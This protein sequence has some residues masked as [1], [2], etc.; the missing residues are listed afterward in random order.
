MSVAPVPHVARPRAAS[1][2][3]VAALLFYLLWNSLY[4]APYVVD[5]AFISFRYARMLL[6]GE[7]LVFNVGERVEGFS[8]FLWVMI[9]AA[10]LALGLP[11]VTATKAV[12]TASGLATGAMTFLL[13][14][15]VLRSRA[16][17]GTPPLDPAPWALLACAGVCVNTSLAVWMQSGLETAFFGL[18]VLASCLR[19]EVERDG[20]RRLP[21]SALLFAAMWMT[22]PEAPAYALY[23]LVRRL[24]SRR[25]EPLGGRDLAWVATVLALVVPYEVW[26]VVYYGHLL[27]NTHV[28][29]VESGDASFF[30]RLLGEPETSQLY[31]FVVDQGPALPALLAL[32]VVGCVRGL[33]KLPVA[34]W[35]PLASGA[36]FLLYAWSDWMPRY[37]FCVPILPFVFLT[38]AFGLR[39][40]DDLV[41]G[42]RVVRGAWLA[43]VA[44]LFTGYAHEQA[45]GSY[46][47]I[48]DR[49]NYKL[50]T[51]AR[52]FWFFDVPAQVASNRLFPLEDV[53]WRILTELRA[54]ETAAIRDIGV[55]GYLTMNPIWDVRG[56]VTPSMARARNGDPD[57]L[58]LVVDE[59]LDVRPTFILLGSGTGN[60]PARVL[61]RALRD[62]ERIL[63]V[64]ARR[65][66]PRGGAE[67]RLRD[68]TPPDTAARVDAAL[69]GFPEY[70]REG[71]PARAGSR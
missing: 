63:A 20:T 6:A 8:N 23:F 46:Y 56:L 33:R 25:S 71:R 34:C 5:D 21:F 64:Y 40:L 45:F 31:R 18:L 24:A 59:L 17:A 48:K 11:I 43:L 37:R 12:G 3:L 16:S 58:A 52:D 47:K 10:I 42:R 66:P 36:V 49:E 28:A 61:D 32:G 15:R 35:A 53:S 68:W 19:F 44:V 57:A 7:G 4:F 22:R 41:R 50:A 30:G 2:L 14:R 60:H 54:H 27:P 69:A 39:Q 62:D 55:P 51:D 13:G 29:K 38:T 70:A 9:E 26:G 1:L 65:Q 67:Y